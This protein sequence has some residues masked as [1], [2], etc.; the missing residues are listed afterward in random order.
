MAR[1]DIEDSVNLKGVVDP[2]PVTPPQPKVVPP[3]QQVATFKWTTTRIY[4][5]P[6]EAGGQAAGQ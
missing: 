6:G 5:R 1:I 4:G 3:P 2:T